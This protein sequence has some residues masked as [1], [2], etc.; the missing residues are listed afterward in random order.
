MTSHK[1]L[2][3]MRSRRSKSVGGRAGVTPCFSSQVPRSEAS[4]L[5]ATSTLSKRGQ[6]N[7]EPGV[8]E[9]ELRPPERRSAWPTAPV[10]GGGLW[11]DLPADMRQRPGPGVGAHPESA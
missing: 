11:L 2:L 5:T 7:E 10:S 8:S 6:R 9:V 3:L 4:A 1:R